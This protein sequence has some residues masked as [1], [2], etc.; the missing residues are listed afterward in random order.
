MTERSRFPKLLET[1]NNLRAHSLGFHLQ[2][3]G[4]E[5]VIPSFGRPQSLIN[6]E[7]STAD[8]VIV[9]FWNR[10]GSPSSTRSPRTATVEEFETA[11]E[12]FNRTGRPVVWVYFKRPTAEIDTQLEG[13]LNFRR[14]L[15]AGRQIF[16]REFETS[17]DWEEMFREHLVAFLDGLE[18]STLDANFQ[19]SDPGNELLSGRFYGEGVSIR[20]SRVELK[21]DLDGDSHDEQV[22]LWFSHSSHKLTVTKFD[23]KVYLRLPDSFSEERVRCAH[24]AIKDVNNDGLPEILLAFSSGIAVLKLAIWGYH[25]ESHEFSSESFHLIQELEGQNQAKVLEGGTILLPY[26]SV[27]CKWVCRWNGSE[28]TVTDE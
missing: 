20:G 3:V 13:V 9:M 18:R 21:I 22:A 16:F 25:S 14:D 8:L 17:L 2:A 28:F 7:L 11:C 10:I 6:S 26:G 19:S 15:E 4:W 5:R 24:L 23:K 27:G 1:V 12:R